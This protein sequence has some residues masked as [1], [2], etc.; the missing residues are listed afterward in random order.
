MLGAFAVGKTSLV[1]RFVDGS[2]SDR[3]ESTVGVKIHKKSLEV[4][5][6]ATS[7]LLWDLHGDDEFQRVRT[8]YL[9]GA[10]GI[11]LVAD[12]T[13]PGTLERAVGLGELARGELG[14]VP[15]LLLL[16]KA[17]L[18]DEWAL[19]PEDLASLKAAGWSV[20]ETSA[21]SGGGVEE[22]FELLCERMAQA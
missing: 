19:G 18:T 4:D 3:Y 1:R 17:D 12:G 13:R 15:F 7:L 20:L 2:F 14:D 5:G 8:T 21:K 16:N 10:S 11:F 22:A 9:R 6:E